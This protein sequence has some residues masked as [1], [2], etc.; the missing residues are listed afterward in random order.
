MKHYETYLI[1]ASDRFIPERYPLVVKELVAITQ[2]TQESPP[3]FKSEII[4]SFLKNESLK[5]DWLIQN[6]ALSE[7]MRSGIIPAQN[8]KALFSACSKND[9]FKRALEIYVYETIHDLH[10]TPTGTLM[11]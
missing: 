1:K 2:S 8:T 5:N 7:M 9:L 10:S 3:L 4:L 6:A 11:T